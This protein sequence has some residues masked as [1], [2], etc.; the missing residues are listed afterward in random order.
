MRIDRSV[1]RLQSTAN[2]NTVERSVRSYSSPTCTSPS[3]FYPVRIAR[4]VRPHCTM[5]VQRYAWCTGYKRDS[6]VQVCRGMVEFPGG[7]LGVCV[8]PRHRKREGSKS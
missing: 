5:V 3:L 2:D 7:S 8:Q 6:R 1:H 4:S